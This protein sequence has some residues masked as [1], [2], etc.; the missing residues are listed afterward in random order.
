MTLL[1]DLQLQP[2]DDKDDDFSCTQSPLDNIT[3]GEQVDDGS[4]EQFWNEVVD[5]IHKDPT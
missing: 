4:L 1:K 2:I 5:D 3:L